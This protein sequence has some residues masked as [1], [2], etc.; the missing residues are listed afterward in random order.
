[1]S[2]LHPLPRHTSDVYEQ[3]S[4]T[5][6]RFADAKI[7]P[8]AKELDES[9]ALPADLYEE[10]A[11][12]GLF[13]ISVPA[14]HG[15]AGLDAFS[16]AL[17]ME[18]LSRGYASVADQCGLVELIA[19]LLSRHGTPAQRERYLAPLLRGER[20]CAYAITEAEAG[21][22]VAGIRTTATRTAEGWRLDGG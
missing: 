17:V 19:T 11:G 20:R 1:M 12:L 16:Y 22:D 15:G 13:G 6:R 8:R 10:M 14:E 5:A 3:I 9:E 7:R 2:V 18:E 21:S 4:E